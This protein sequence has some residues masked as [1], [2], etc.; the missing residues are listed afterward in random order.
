MNEQYK[1][2]FIQGFWLDERLIDNLVNSLDYPNNNLWE[3]LK[4]PNNY[5]TRD[6]F[7]M[8]QE[9]DRYYLMDSIYRCMKLYS[10]QYPL[11]KHKFEGLEMFPKLNVQIYK[12]GKYYDVLHYESVHMIKNMY[13]FRAFVYMTYLNSLDD[14]HTEF[15]YQKLNIKPQKGLTL[16]WPADW[17]H[18]HIGSPSKDYKKLITGW[19]LL[20]PQEMKNSTLPMLKDFDDLPVLNY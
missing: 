15:F 8:G 7:N 1:D 13:M 12:P 9:S 11:S 3:E 17:T 18:T 19:F 5:D 14:G 20:F 2:K 16:I 6:F 4:P 10:K